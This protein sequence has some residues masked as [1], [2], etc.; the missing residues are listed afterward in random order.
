MDASSTT[1]TNATT[2]PVSTNINL[3][4][5]G[6]IEI[7]QSA[8]KAGLSQSQS[9]M[10]N[11][12]SKIPGSTSFNGGAALFSSLPS[13]DMNALKRP[14][15]WITKRRETLK[16]WSEFF[17]FSK[18]KKPN[19]PGQLGS[20]IFKNVGYFQT[21][22]LFVFVGL[23]IYCVL[24]SPILLLAFLSFI[25]ALYIISLK[26]TDGQFHVLGR[27]V[28][29]AHVYTVVALVS[30]PIFLYAGASTAVFWIIGASM[31][32]IVLHAAF[33]SREEQDPFLL[34]MNIV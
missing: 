15:E 21:N 34:Q 6:D 33:Y 18:Y 27:A 32:V 9:S 2:A 11:N 8:Q 24:T 3:E 13:L 29:L 1:S 17:A 28:S 23:A 30:V 5:E 31:V 25:G 19:G 10:N 14:Q 4:L 16:P 22:Y 7:P 20:R 26:S 12:S